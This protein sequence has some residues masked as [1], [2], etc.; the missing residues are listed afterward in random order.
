[1]FA[2]ATMVCWATLSQVDQLYQ[3]NLVD[4]GRCCFARLDWILDFCLTCYD[5]NV[6]M[7]T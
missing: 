4:I 2:W 5:R 1:M 6:T 3:I 7:E